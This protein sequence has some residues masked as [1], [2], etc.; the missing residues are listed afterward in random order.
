MSDFDIIQAFQ[1]KDDKSAYELSI[2]L[3]SLSA[4]SPELYGLFD[5]FLKLRKTG[6]TDVM[7]VLESGYFIFNQEFL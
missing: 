2:E 7:S 5:D 4:S 3:I 6:V 1:D